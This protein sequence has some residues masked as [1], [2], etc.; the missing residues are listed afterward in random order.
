MPSG[1]LGSA[2]HLSRKGVEFK[3]SMSMV[4]QLHC[5]FTCIM[6]IV[7]L[8]GLISFADSKRKI[9]PWNLVFD[10]TVIMRS[11]LKL[12]TKKDQDSLM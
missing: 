9:F 8:K 1:T 4:F 11:M 12:S 3:M 10:I 5:R 2:S 7:H 6:G